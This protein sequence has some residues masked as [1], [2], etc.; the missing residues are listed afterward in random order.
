MAQGSVSE[1]LRYPIGFGLV[2]NANLQHVSVLGAELRGC[3][4]RNYYID[5]LGKA[6]QK[7]ITIPAAMQ[8]V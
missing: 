1:R 7:I 3:D 8:K 4:C 5:R 6:I 2:C